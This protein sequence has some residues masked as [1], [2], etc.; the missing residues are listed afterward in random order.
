MTLRARLRRFAVMLAFAAC[1]SALGAAVEAS[2][3]AEGSRAHAPPRSAPARATTHGTAARP[4]TGRRPA[5]PP[6]GAPPGYRE[7]VRGWHATAGV[8]PTDEHGRPLLVLRAINTNERITL[9]ATTDSGGFSASDLD[10][11]SYLLRDPSTG[12]QHPVEPSALDLVYRIQRHFASGEIRVVSGYRTPKGRPSNHGKGRAIDLVVAG[13]ADD[14]VAKWAREQGF[15]GVGI[16]P[17][18]GF[19]H[20]DRRE[21]SYFWVDASGPGKKNRERGIFGDIAQ[22]SDQRAS[23]R[24]EHPIGPY[25]LGNSVDAVLSA[26]APAQ[27]PPFDEDDD[28][29]AENGDE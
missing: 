23:G 22:R 19:V 5:R 18:S 8:P 10:R 3:R 21:R 12:N 4:T 28:T 13:A 25:E 14:D 16:Y 11:A 27:S 2:A 26:I 17:V 7:A 6:R 24:N 9:P 15:V 1:F 29:D 20:V